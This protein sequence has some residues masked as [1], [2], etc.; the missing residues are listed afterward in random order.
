MGERR[1]AS[2]LAKNRLDMRLTDPHQTAVG[3]V[4]CGE[5][6][7]DDLQLRR[8]QASVVV[9]EQPSGGLFEHAAL[10]APAAVE[11]GLRAAANAIDV[12]PD[13]ATAPAGGAIIDDA[14]QHAFV[15]AGADSGNSF[16]RLVA[17]PTD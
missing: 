11:F 2:Q 13:P 9:G 10:A 4:H 5:G 12:E 7:D 1:V 6:V 14:G 16:S 17:V 15:A 3:A 8:D